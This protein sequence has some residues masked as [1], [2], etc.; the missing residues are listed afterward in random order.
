MGQEVVRYLQ[1]K[2]FK[3]ALKKHL[4]VSIQAKTDVP[5]SPYISVWLNDK[6]PGSLSL[7]RLCIHLSHM[8]PFF[9]KKQALCFLGLGAQDLPIKTSTGKENKTLFLFLT[10]YALTFLCFT[11]GIQWNTNF[12]S[13]PRL[14]ELV[15]K[16]LSVLE[17]TTK[18]YTILK[19]NNQM[20]CLH[21]LR[22]E[23]DFC[24]KKHLAIPY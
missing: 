19:E 4:P 16:W 8:D 1:Q 21:H 22:W 18:T 6:S 10:L 12:S 7:H 3:C 17:K 15:S 5:L 2:S 23:K 13:F 20:P 9:S 14:R 11:C 24:S